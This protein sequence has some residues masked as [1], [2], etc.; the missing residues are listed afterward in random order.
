MRPTTRVGEES[1]LPER[2]TDDGD[3]WCARLLVGF[4]MR[5]TALRHT[6]ATRNPDAVISAT[7]I[8]STSRSHAR[9]RSTRATA[10]RSSI[11]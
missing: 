11:V 7:A 8:G 1:P 2:V 9:L 5:P 10:P 3:R 6:R 4:D